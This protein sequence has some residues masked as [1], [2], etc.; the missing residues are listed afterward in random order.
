[1]KKK[2]VVGLLT[3]FMSLG[4]SACAHDGK[5]PYI[6]DNGNWWV[7]D[8]DLGVP[9]TGPEGNTGEQGQKGTSVVSIN[10]TS[11]DGLV[12]TYTITFSDGSTTTFTVTNG[13]SNVIES[14]ELT[15]SSGLTDTYTITFT[16]GS[17]KTF[18]VTNGANGQNLTITSIELK[19][20][21][22]LIDTY[23][24]NYSD[25]SKF[26]FVVSNGADGQTPY[27]GDNGNWWIGD[28]DTGVLA[29]WEKANNVPLTI[30]SNG[31]TYTTATLEGKSGFVV[32]G[33][34][35]DWL[36]ESLYYEMISQ[37]MSPD[38][39]E[40]YAEEI[41]DGVETGH[42][43]I[44]NYI[45]SVPV[46]GIGA[47]ADLNF[48][49]VT[50]S[51][52]TICLGRG[53]FYNCNYLKEV[54][55]NNANIEYIPEWAFKN[56]SVGNIV[57]PSSVKSIGEEAF[58]G[59]QM[60]SFDIGNI[61]YI[62]RNALDSL[63]AKYVYLPKTVQYVGDSAFVSARVYIE[64][65]TYPSTWASTI[66]T[67]HEETNYLVS[68]NC[69]MNYEYIYSKANNEVT[70]YQ[71]TGSNKKITIPSTID[72]CPVTKI[73]YGFNTPVEKRS[74]IIVN[75][76]SEIKEYIDLEEIVIPEG[77]EEI[78][79]FSLCG[80]GT[81]IFA[82]SSLERISETY[83]EDSDDIVSYKL[84]NEEILFAPNYLALKGNE[85][86]DVLDFD[87]QEP[88][89]G[90][91]REYLET[92]SVYRV[93]FEIN[94]S[95]IESDDKFYYLNNGSSYSIL[96]YKAYNGES[97]AIP[98]SF[99]NKPITT[100]MG[101][102]IPFD[103]SIKN[104]KIESGINR[105]RPFGVCCYKVQYMSIPY[106]VSAINANG[107]Y[108]DDR[109]LQ[110]FV[111]AASKPVD[112]DSN[113]TNVLN[114]V[115]FGVDGEIGFSNFFVYCVKNNCVTLISYLGTSSNVF[116]PEEID[117][118]IV[119]TIKAGFYERNG[120]AEIYIPS[121]ITNIESK[122]FVNIS[123]KQFVIHGE[124]AEEPSNWNENWYY[125]SRSGNNY[126]YVNKIWNESSLFNYQ[127]NEDY[128]F[129]VVDE[130]ISLLAFCGNSLNV[131]IPR[132]IANKNVTTIKEYCF[133]FETAA[134][135]YI[136]NEVLTIEQAGIEHYTSS[137]SNY[138]NVYC[139]PQSKPGGWDSYFAL[140]TYY[141]SSYY[142]SIYYGRNIG[143]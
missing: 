120:G 67:Q 104:I 22:G 91:T 20:R 99:N 102:A 89:T 136:P 2:F 27:I 78:E 35:N 71:Y 38:E 23:V 51:R 73:G 44:P 58:S 5:T 33:W 129:S 112:W 121:S 6:G 122:A 9:A 126:S 79:A 77:V 76:Y 87:S 59:V 101:K 128:V 81:T 86:P 117:G 26:E 25:G 88:L 61:T 93:G 50:L 63:E 53:A 42:L 96:S 118:K 116:I 138:L 75:D 7:G 100:I 57:L 94:Y 8:S 49:K 28:E 11:S 39:A 142:I 143:Y 113:W 105:I 14:I 109:S 114:N 21:E 4:L 84:N 46:I 70:V 40:E 139:E 83:F 80:M 31:L 72:G 30:Y 133:H 55:F 66:T 24:I 111:S 140:N 127:L 36:G 60:S 103:S 137:S 115:V 124:S 45:G 29:D 141:Q 107:I 68:T 69:K 110:I 64:H 47:E 18:T 1:M 65:E 52:N 3:I 85:M 16:N 10:K 37:G 43:V 54:D 123:S 17:T 74:A 90:F 125:S 82:P 19:S 41:I 15:S 106:S 135:I 131:K 48:G 32:T 130:S 13:E 97:L 119:T 34:D 56:T 62:G 12:D 132:Q 98:S 134:S 108:S 95:N 92:Q